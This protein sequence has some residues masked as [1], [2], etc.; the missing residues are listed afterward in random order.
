MK[1]AISGVT[2]GIAVFIVAHTTGASEPN[3]EASVKQDLLSFGQQIQQKGTDFSAIW[4][5]F[6]PVE[7]AFIVVNESQ[8]TLVYTPANAPLVDDHAGEALA[9]NFYYYPTLLPGL[10]DFKYEIDFALPDDQ[11]ATAINITDGG[12]IEDISTLIHEAFHGY[13]RRNFS[14]QDEVNFLPPEALESIETRALLALQYELARRVLTTPEPEIIRDWLQLRRIIADKVPAVAAYLAYMEQIE[15]TAQWVG[16]TATQQTQE[17]FVESFDK[18]FTSFTSNMNR[19]L[20]V[21]TSAYV[22]GAT[23]LSVIEAQ[24]SNRDW[25]QQIEQGV[26]PLELAHELFAIEAANEQLPTLLEQYD[27]PSFV[28]AIEADATGIASVADVEQTHPY[29]LDIHVKVSPEEVAKTGLPMKF[30]A[31]NAGFHELEKSLLLLPDPHSFQITSEQSL[32]DIRTLPVRIDMR[33]LAEGG[34]RISVWSKDP[35]LQIQGLRSFDKTQKLE[36]F[37][38]DSSVVT[39][40]TWQLDSTSTAEHVVLRLQ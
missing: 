6:W 13:Q 28:A 35:W 17:A 8:Q 23:L 32:V 2:L 18:L 29:L 40:A 1:Q 21:R 20:D 34:V 5:G 12:K 25:Q 27:Y 9:N 10:D 38:G 15:G 31:G 26:T 7:Q 4:P 39:E 24:S 30:N 3:N 37:F 16:M 19:P 11:L 36:L 22:T 33:A 14:A